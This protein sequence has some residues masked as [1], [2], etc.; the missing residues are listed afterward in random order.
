[1]IAAFERFLS[2]DFSGTRQKTVVCSLL[3]SELGVLFLSDLRIVIDA[4]DIIIPGKVG[5]FF[6]PLA[7]S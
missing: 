1:M 3:E 2:L 4:R 7:I 6:R 5:K